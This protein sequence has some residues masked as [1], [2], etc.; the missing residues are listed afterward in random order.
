MSRTLA[1]VGATGGAGT[2]RLSVELGATLARDGLDVAILDAA[3]ATQ[4]LAQY[5]SGRIDPDITAL[6]VGDQPLERG[7]YDLVTSQPGRVVACPAAAPFERLARAK[8]PESARRF[9]A[10]VDEAEAVA[11]YV[12]LDTPPV[13]ANQAVS[14]A[15][16]ADDAV[17]VVPASERGADALALARDRLRDIGVDEPTVVANGA[18]GSNPVG[19]TAIAVPRSEI[20]RPSAAPATLAPDDSFAPAV[21]DVARATL[22]VDPSLEYD[23]TGGLVESL[24]IDL[25]W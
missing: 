13:A 6:T 21:A 14:A 16:T 4:G 19:G 17:L 9:E 24:P 10:L 23:E 7:L 2:T 18:S 25:E 8:T 22:G 11:D 1:L 12:L 20:T 15:T 5:V 3:Y